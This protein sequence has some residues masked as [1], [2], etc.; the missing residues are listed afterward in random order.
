MYTSTGQ[1]VKAAEYLDKSLKLIQAATKGD[2]KL[3][4]CVFQNLGAV[5]NQLGSFVKANIYHE[6]AIELYGLLGMRYA[7]GQ[8][9]SNLGFAFGQ[10]G[11]L[12][13]SGQYFMHALQAAKDCQ[14]FR[15]QWQANE[16]LSAVYFQQK[17]YE[18]AVNCLK[19]ALAI[20]P[21]GHVND[22]AIHERIVAKLS[23]ALENQLG[24]S[25]PSEIPYK[26]AVMRE[27]F[28]APAVNVDESSPKIGHIRP[29]EKNHKLI[30]RGLALAEHASD[31]ED[32]NLSDS[33]FD[34]ISSY[35]GSSLSIDQEQQ[36]SKQK[37]T[38]LNV[39]NPGP[40]RLTPPVKKDPLNN[41]YEEPLDII[42]VLESGRLRLHDLP[43]GPRDKVL[44]SMNDSSK[45]EH[46]QEKT[47]VVPSSNDNAKSR[48][49]VVQ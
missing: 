27:K 41:T 20:L 24:N 36:A 7:Q 37:N 8:S 33:T 12:E 21:Q 45:Q 9:F 32:D 6:K 46:G 17:D 2:Q 29:R 44:A 13:K 42:Q 4:A 40:S 3:E 48:T 10:L 43:R 39:N 16:G 49:C 19:A 5:H 25:K 15:G 28:A 14:D 35:S 1:Y 22:Q 38:E 26:T 30:A 18:K 47:K 31:V 11:E 23:N 34:S